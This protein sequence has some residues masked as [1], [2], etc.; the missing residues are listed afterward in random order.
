MLSKVADFYEA[1]VDQ[2]VD[3]LKSVIEPLML[4]IVG[5]IVGIIVAAIM[6]PMF[7]MYDNML[8]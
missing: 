6:S 8:N 2:S 5:C 3:R 4:L 7:K 1:D